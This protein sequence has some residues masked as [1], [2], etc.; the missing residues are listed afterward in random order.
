MLH[1]A[2][3]SKKDAVKMLIRNSTQHLSQKNK[4]MLTEIEMRILLFCIMQ[5]ISRGKVLENLF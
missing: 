2:Q 3:H 1:G 5:S 4:L